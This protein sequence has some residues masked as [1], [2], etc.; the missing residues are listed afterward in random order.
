MLPVRGADDLD[1]DE[2]A[3]MVLHD[4]RRIDRI[5][6]A[7]GELLGRVPWQ[8]FGTHT[9]RI[10]K[11][12]RSG[13]VHPEAAH[14]AFRFFVSSINRE[15]YGRDWG[16][17]W[18]RGCQWAVGE[19]LHKDGRLHLHSVIS[20]PTGD[21]Y[22]LLSFRQW[23]EFWRKEFGNNRLEAPRSQADVAGYLSKYVSKEGNVTLS[24]N[25]GAWLPPRP[26]YHAT[27]GQPEL[28][29]TGQQHPITCGQLASHA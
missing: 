2:S 16:R 4:V 5:A 19:E 20:A 18:H 10:H 11:A 26:T 24:P 14:K 27:P 8:L 25:F 6:Q 12:G 23:H 15:L 29:G 7:Y 28:I 9:F 22:R 21:L 13:G 3:P 1:A 17:R